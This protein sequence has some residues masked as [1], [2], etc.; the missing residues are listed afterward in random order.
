M[1]IGA[2][3]SCQSVSGAGKESSQ[4]LQYSTAQSSAHPIQANF[5]GMATSSINDRPDG[6]YGWPTVPFGGCRL[7]AA[8]GTD[9][10]QQRTYSWAGLDRAVD[11]CLSQGKEIMYTFGS[12]PNWMNGAAATCGN[13][14]CQSGKAPLNNQDWFDFVTALV[15]RYKGKIKYYELWNEPN[16]Y[17][18][19]WAGTVPQLMILVKREYKI[20]KQIDPD[21]LTIS[22][23]T[24]STNGDISY[25]TDLLKNGAG[26]YADFIGF[27]GYTTAHYK[28]T[29]ATRSPEAIVADLNSMHAAMD[30]YG[31]G[32]KQLVDAESSWNMC[33]DKTTGF[34][35]NE[36]LQA[37]FVAVR[38]IIYA[39]DGVHSYWWYAWD[40]DNAAD[41]YW[42]SLYHRNGINEANPHVTKAGVAYGEVENWLVGATPA[43]SGCSYPSKNTW[44]CPITRPGGY[45]GLFVW[46]AAGSGTFIVPAE[47]TRMRDLDGGT[48]IVAP[49]VSIS[50]SYKPVLLENEAP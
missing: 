32:S 41:T 21:A 8:H 43:S 29:T 35:G 31:V 30:T 38:H 5:F 26:D 11:F 49:G 16:I 22:P 7:W 13:A 40:G 9:V 47:M 23:S 3:T 36:D 44:A 50:I 19:G 18:N 37:A 48:T 1:M 6:F 10:Y 46:N 14:F 45:K 39:M 25:F 12:V 17:P 27:H 2:A 34:C 20:I 42:G 33:M 4:L 24:G 15:Q 28:A